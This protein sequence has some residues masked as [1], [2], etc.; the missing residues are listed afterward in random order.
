MSQPLVEPVRRNQ[1]SARLQRIAERGLRGCRFRSGV[2]HLGG[3]RRV[4]CPRRNEPPA[5]HRQFADRLLWMLAND[6]DRLGRRNIVS[7]TPVLP[8]R[9]AVEVLLDKLLPSRQSVAPA[10]GRD[11]CRLGINSGHSSTRKG[12][13]EG[14]NRGHNTPHWGTVP[15][16]NYGGL[17]S[18]STVNLG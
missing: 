13:A 1:A 10:H 11:Y 5:H 15:F 14:A 8:F 18:R 4:F 7:G 12:W 17:P 6:R 3:G 2:N 9:D 16:R